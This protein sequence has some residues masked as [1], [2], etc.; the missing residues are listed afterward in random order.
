MVKFV[1]FIDDFGLIETIPGEMSWFMKDRAKPQS[2]TGELNPVKEVKDIIPEVTLDSDD[3]S[4]LDVIPEEEELSDPEDE[5]EEVEG[6]KNISYLFNDSVEMMYMAQ[7]DVEEALVKP[8]NES[9]VVT[10]S[11]GSEDSVTA[12]G[13]EDSRLLHTSCESCEATSM[14]FIADEDTAMMEDV[15][16]KKSK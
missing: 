3:D 16:P 4:S 9:Q 7:F 12:N 11:S 15:F 8:I 10:L 1:T 2:L 14:D 13:P 5:G 6:M